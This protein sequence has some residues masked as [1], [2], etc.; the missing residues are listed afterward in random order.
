VGKEAAQSFDRQRINLRKLN[1]PEVREHYQ[2]E[3]TNRFAGLEKVNVE[4][5]VRK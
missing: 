1:E 4:E 3:I 5:D 2:N